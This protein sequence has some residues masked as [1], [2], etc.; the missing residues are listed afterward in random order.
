[1]RPMLR[2]VVGLA[3]WLAARA[4]ARGG[5]GAV[6]HRERRARRRRERG[7]DGREL[8]PLPPAAARLRAYF[9]L[10]RTVD[11]RAYYHDLEMSRCHAEGR[12]T[13][14]GG[15]RGRWRID[16]ERRGLVLLPPGAGPIFLH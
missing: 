2:A 13:F 16:Q 3:T 1:V 8:R 11:W 9:R 7:R 6:R 15:W 4:P 14:A 5:D 12:V 10:A